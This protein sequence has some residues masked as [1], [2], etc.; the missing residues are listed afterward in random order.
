MASIFT[1]LEA[2]NGCRALFNNVKGWAYIGPA[3]EIDPNAHSG[4]VSFSINSRRAGTEAAAAA[5]GAADAPTHQSPVRNGLPGDGVARKTNEV[6]SAYRDGADLTQLLVEGSHF[7]PSGRGLPLASAEGVADPLR[8][9]KGFPIVL[10][11]QAI[12]SGK[13]AASTGSPE[14]SAPLDVVND[15]QDADG[16]PQVSDH[17]HFPPLRSPELFLSP[18]VVV[19]PGAAGVSGVLSCSEAVAEAS[20]AVVGKCGT[21]G[22]GGV[23]AAASRV[24][25]WLR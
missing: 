2:H 24:G 12:L 7:G 4:T 18:P 1:S 22:P 3:G 6:L 10:T 15:N 8:P 19:K 5:A 11:L 25:W 9:R 17:T 23:G 13:P 16:P 14:P 21:G 20:A